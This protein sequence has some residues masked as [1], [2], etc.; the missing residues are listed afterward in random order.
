MTYKTHPST[1]LIVSLFVTSINTSV[2]NTNTTSP[3]LKE[4]FTEFV[5]VTPAMADGGWAGYS[6]TSP[7]GPTFTKSLG[8]FYAVPNVSW[9]VANA[10][11]NP[12]FD[13]ARALAARSSVETIGQLTILAAGT[14]PVASFATLYDTYLANTTG[15]VGDN[16]EITSRLLPRTTIEQGHESVADTLLSFPSA[17]HQ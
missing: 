8:F 15:Q 6:T 14:F 11:M 5:R 2:P 4:L 7:M 16:V 9:A 12:F 1:P 13:F 17:L 3:V 10:T